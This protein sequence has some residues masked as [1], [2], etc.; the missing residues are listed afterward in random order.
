MTYPTMKAPRVLMPSGGTKAIRHEAT[1]FPWEFTLVH[2]VG[3]D[4]P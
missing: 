4:R 3:N 2:K 1:K